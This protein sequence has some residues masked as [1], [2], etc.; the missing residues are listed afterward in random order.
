[1]CR[2]LKSTSRNPF[3][4]PFTFVPHLLSFL[5]KTLFKNLQ[6]IGEVWWLKL[7]ILSTTEVEIKRLEV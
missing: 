1:M 6:E 2:L 4:I 3:L 5:L 7:E